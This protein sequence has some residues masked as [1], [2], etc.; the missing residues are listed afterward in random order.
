V[1][2]V[3]CYAA[4]PYH[5]PSLGS[6][7]HDAG[8]LLGV[9][10]CLQFPVSFLSGAFFTVSGAVFRERIASSQASAGL[11][12][13]FN[14]FGAA[15]G[16][17]VAGFLLVPGIG[18]E[19]SFFVLALVYGGAA[20]LWSRADEGSRRWLWVGA[21]VWVAAL[22]LF[23][24]GRFD[25]RY[26][27]A[28][29][30]LFTKA[31]NTKIRAVRE[32]L[33]ETV[34]YVQHEKF[35]RILN[36]RMVANSF[37]MS[38][39]T[40]ASDRYMKQFV[41]W[42]VALHPAPRRALL[43][44]FGVGG[45]ARAMTRTRELEQIDVVDLSRDILDLSSIVFPDPASH[46][47]HDPRVRVHVEDGRFF[48]QTRAQTWDIITG[49]PPPPDHPGIA[50]LYSREY[51]QLVKDRL[52]EGGIATYWIPIHTLTEPAARSVLKAW[53]EVFENGFLWRGARKDL[54]VVG[55]KGHPGRVSEERFS[56]QWRDPAT[57]S[58]LRDVGFDL[59]E[60]L[61]TGFV[62]DADYI[63]SICAT[64]EPTVDAYPKRIVAPGPS[65]QKMY[66]SWFDVPASAERF[67]KSASLSGLWPPALREKTQAYFA[68]E[69]ALTTLGSVP[70]KTRQ[71]PF[72][73]LHRLCQTPGLGMLVM[74]ALD[75]DRDL[76]RAAELADP[77]VQSQPSAQFHL[78]ARALAQ[79][80]Y[81]RASDHFLRTVGTAGMRKLD[82]MVCLYALCRA[83]RKGDAERTLA[84]VWNEG[85]RTAMPP[86]YWPWMKATFGLELPR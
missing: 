52:S 35:D 3:P 41:Y 37:S 53:S 19:K 51:F 60:L 23:P 72:S 47:L 59:P 54:M 75:S 14:T 39:T 66:E 55:I 43:I 26:I 80:D 10:F 65:E 67:A 33:T 17:V 32:G 61:G 50:G 48:L 24:F 45:T 9:G 25:R 16:A 44:C 11:L 13:L 12:V 38:A 29:T 71:P 15:T 22:A 27:P 8:T 30:Q 77:E 78:G 76:V 56:A 63:R 79:R 70:W 36:H 64:A 84:G 21:G 73:E 82:L 20:F 6:Y 5:T 31:P 83:R 58:E 74:W 7:V 4:F 18:V 86:D 40:V 57:L 62:G 46:P 34:I 49:E 68:W 42:P 1:A 69:T 2:L 28:S 85:L 81:G